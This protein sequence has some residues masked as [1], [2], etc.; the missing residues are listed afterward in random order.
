MTPSMST[1]G[2]DTGS[3]KYTGRTVFHPSDIILKILEII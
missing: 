3:E 1:P 2:V